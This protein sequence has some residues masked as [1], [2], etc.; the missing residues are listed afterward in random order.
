MVDKLELPKWLLRGIE[1]SFPLRKIDR[2]TMM[3]ILE[4]VFRSVLV[5]QYGTDENVNVFKLFKF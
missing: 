5:K 3:N 2:E 1:E 4:D